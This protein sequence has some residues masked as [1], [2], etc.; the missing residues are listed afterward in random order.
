MSLFVS[1]RA[2]GSEQDALDLIADAYHLHQAEWVV[3]QRDQL[4]AEFFT[5]SSGVAGAIVQKFVNY[6]MRLAVVG[7]VSAHEA[8]SKPFRDWVRETNRGKD[9]WFVPDL[10]SF[11]ERRR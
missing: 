8:A 1:D 6:R 11:E 5:L 4:P 2:I 9:V 7:D 10:A 3:L